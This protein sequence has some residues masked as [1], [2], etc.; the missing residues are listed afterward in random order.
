[1]KKLYTPPTT[2]FVRFDCGELMDYGDFSGGAAISGSHNNLGPR[3]R[4]LIRR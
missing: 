2:A 3:Y 4:A 1:M